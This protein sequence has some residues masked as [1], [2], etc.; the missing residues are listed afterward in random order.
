M[1]VFPALQE[2]LL[3]WCHSAGS[4]LDP[5]SPD[6]NVWAWHSMLYALAFFLDG[7]IGFLVKTNKVWGL[8]VLSRQRCT[9]WSS[10][11]C[12]A[13]YTA[14]KRKRERGR[15]VN[16]RHTMHSSQL[17]TWISLFPGKWALCISINSG[18][19][20]LSRKREASIEL[21]LSNTQ[22]SCVKEFLF[23]EVFSCI[24]GRQRWDEEWERGPGFPEAHSDLASWKQVDCNDIY[25]FHLKINLIHH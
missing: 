2:H 11:L 18:S 9:R 17:Q 25:F 21:A 16:T 24:S 20:L 1:H 22:L 12:S 14:K 23:C 5:A 13:P 8:T 19:V 6:R 15:S 4:C 7:F 10:L 3:G